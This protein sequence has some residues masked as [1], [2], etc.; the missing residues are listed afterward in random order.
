MF[1]PSANGISSNNMSW[2]KFRWNENMKTLLIYCHVILYQCDL[3]NQTRR[4]FFSL[5]GIPVYSD[6]FLLVDWINPDLRI[7]NWESLANFF[8]TL[9]S[10]LMNVAFYYV[11][12]IGGKWCFSVVD[13]TVELLHHLHLDRPVIC[14]SSQ[15]SSRSWAFPGWCTSLTRCIS[16]SVSLPLIWALHSVHCGPR[17]ERKLSISL[18]LSLIS[19]TYYYHHYEHYYYNKQW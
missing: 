17:F 1:I 15:S 16:S 4:F 12:I 8:L 13:S 7:L 2:F 11:K 9:L 5:L 6:L 3:D 19:L 18:P 10:Y 14:C